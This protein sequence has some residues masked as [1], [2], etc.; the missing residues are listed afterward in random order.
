MS[1]TNTTTSQDSTPTE[2]EIVTFPTEA[3]INK[4]QQKKFPVFNAH[5]VPYSWYMRGDVL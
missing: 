4:L 2:E 1:N 3:E 5:K